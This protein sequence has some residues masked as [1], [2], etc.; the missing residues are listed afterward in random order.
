MKKILLALLLSISFAAY[1]Q[2]PSQI[3]Y[4]G[5]ARNSVGNVLPNKKITVRLSVHD[6]TATG[7]VVYSEARNITTSSLGLF[8]IAIGS[9][10]A[11]STTGNF[12]GI[13]WNSGAK[14]LQVEVDPDG[15]SNFLNLGT[16]PLL[17][18]PYSLYAANAGNATPSGNAGGDLVGTYP[19][20]VV[21]DKAITTAKLNDSS[22]S[23]IKIQDLAVT[24]NKLAD[25]S[26]TTSK[27]VDSSIT[28]VKLGSDVILAMGGGGGGNPTGPAG[29]DLSGIYPNP[30]VKDAAITG[31]KL[32]DNAVTT[33]KI[34]DN[35][36]TT[37][38]VVDS[39]I[40]LIKL[41]SDVIAAMGGGGGGGNPTG[42]AGGDLSG[43]YP[44]PSVKNGAI[45]G[46]KL[47]DNAVTTVKILDASVT[48]A[49]LAPGVI[50][51]T[52]PPTGPAGGDLIGTY[53][54]PIIADASV[55]QNKIANNSVGTINLMNASVSTIK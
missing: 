1:A 39:S 28:L 50:P 15:G 23:T 19:N 52:L 43:L 45:T 2:V 25:N 12:A 42:P 47:A 24:N 9:G 53:P 14:F 38:K 46:I 48:S 55:T 27:V 4:Q 41:G 16:S 40:T 5:I 36:I 20:P 35:S 17:A 10:G 22:V 49:K 18:V 34:S 51:S 6:Q 32:A 26:V 29:G 44:N 33:N 30:S 37:P 3:N 54:N 7:T 8:T 13:N 21:A 11:T 31:N